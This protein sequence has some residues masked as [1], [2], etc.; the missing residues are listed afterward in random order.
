VF[1]ALAS[2][3]DPTLL[4]QSSHHGG[5]RFAANLLALPTGI[6]LG[7]ISPA[8]ATAAATLLAEGR[9]PLEHYRGRTLYEP[10]AQAAEVEVRRRLGLDRVD[11]LELGGDD[12]ERVTFV[13][14]TGEVAVTVEERP[15]PVIAVSCGQEAE[16]TVAFSVRW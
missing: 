11:D 16:E 10:R 3:V 13:H 9:I 6:Q 15:G 12:G 14:A 5:H 8:Q 7:R 1:D 4:W 2:E